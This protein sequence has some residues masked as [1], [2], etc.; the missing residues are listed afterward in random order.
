[1]IESILSV[2]I[3]IGTSTTELVFSIIK[4]ENTASFASVPRISIVDKEVIYR[5]DIYLTPLISQTEIDGLKLKDI[6]QMEYKR[7]G[8]RPSDISTGVAIITGETARKR[9]QAG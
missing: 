2:G 5:S 4:I 6:V 1:M 8:I 9:M 3:D 7:A